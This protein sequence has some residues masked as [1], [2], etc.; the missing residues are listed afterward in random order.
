MVVKKRKYRIGAKVYLTCCSN[1]PLIPRFGTRIRIVPVRSP[2]PHFR[3]FVC[4]HDTKAPP[5]T[6]P[7]VLRERGANV[8]G[9]LKNRTHKKSEIARTTKKT[10]R[11]MMA[12][13]SGSSSSGKQQQQPQQQ[14]QQQQQQKGPFDDG[15]QQQQ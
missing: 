10:R 8:D 7:N 14:Q 4:W 6:N 3:F 2:V 11:T 1:H 9:S 15:Y 12:T 5:P 13:S